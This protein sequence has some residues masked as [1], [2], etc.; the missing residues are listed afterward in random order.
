MGWH[1]RRHALSRC[2][3]F[4]AI[5]GFAPTQREGLRRINQSQGRQAPD[6]SH[7]PQKFA[8]GEVYD[9]PWGCRDRGQTTAPGRHGYN[10]APMQDQFEHQQDQASDG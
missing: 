5:F 10:P 9:R 7:G 3:A 1:A 6:D 8:P 4:G 2:R